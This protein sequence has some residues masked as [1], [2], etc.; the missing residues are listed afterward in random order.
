MDNCEGS[1]SLLLLLFGTRP[2]AP[3]RGGGIAAASDADDVDEKT[4]LGA[5]SDSSDSL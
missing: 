2:L 5:L 4:R 1:I 3:R